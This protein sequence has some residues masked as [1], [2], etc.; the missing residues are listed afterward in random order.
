MLSVNLPEWISGT[1]NMTRMSIFVTIDKDEL[2]LL[3]SNAEPFCWLNE[4][5][6]VSVKK[7]RT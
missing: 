4:K 7:D 1:H 3:C 2:H 5:S 6:C